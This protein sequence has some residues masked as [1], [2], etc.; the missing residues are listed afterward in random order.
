MNK[1][2]SNSKKIVIWLCV[3]YCL[4]IAGFFLL[5]TLGSG[6][7]TILWINFILDV[8]LCAISFVL[9]ILLFLPK[10]RVSFLGRMALMLVTLCLCAFT[11]FAFLVPENGLPPVLLTPGA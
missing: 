11:W 10:Y 6:S 5:G 4:F 1:L 9:N 3:N 7:Q 2:P 8:A